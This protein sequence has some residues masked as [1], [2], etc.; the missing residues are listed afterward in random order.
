MLKQE[1]Y[2]LICLMEECGEAIQAASKCLRHGTS[3]YHPDR[4]DMNNWKELCNELM[5]V[6]AVMDLLN[7]KHVIHKDMARYDE[8]QTRIKQ[9]MKERA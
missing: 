8:K 7:K 4:P 2:L 5:D 1:Q 9:F 6:A 3:N